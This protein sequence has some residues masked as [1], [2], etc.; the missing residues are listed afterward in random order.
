MIVRLARVTAAD[1]GRGALVVLWGCDTPEALTAAWW[2]PACWSST[3]DAPSA[4]SSRT[5]PTRSEWP[6]IRPVIPST[7][8]ALADDRPDRVGWFAAT[9]VAV[10]RFAGVDFSAGGAPY[11]PRD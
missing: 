3:R 7:A 8:A 2:A 11:F 10:P 6:P 1:G 4:A 5:V 9:I